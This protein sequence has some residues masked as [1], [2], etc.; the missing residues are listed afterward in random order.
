MTGKK[1][2]ILIVDDEPNI[3]LLVGNLLGGD[4][5]V[6][7][8]S[9]GVEALHIARRQSPDLILMDIMMPDMDGYSACYAIKNDDLTSKIPVVMVTAVGQELNRMFAQQMGAD[10]YITKPF[11]A[12]DLLDTIGRLL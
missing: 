1:G 8:A 12:K 11:Q 9:N 2:T 4:Y 10:G 6:L 3:R 7:E 5:D